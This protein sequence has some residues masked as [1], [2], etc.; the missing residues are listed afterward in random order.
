MEFSQ[1]IF[2][3]HH[4]V[5]GHSI[6]IG[7]FNHDDSSMIIICSVDGNSEVSRNISSSKDLSEFMKNE[8]DPAVTIALDELIEIAEVKYP[9]IIERLKHWNT[10]AKHK[11]FLTYDTVRGSYSFKDF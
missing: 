7:I 2:S 11:E 8:F 9:K 5:N 1:S 10:L 3:N 6:G 4:Y